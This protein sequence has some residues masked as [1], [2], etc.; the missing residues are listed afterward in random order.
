MLDGLAE[1]D[2][3]ERFG[4]ERQRLSVAL[5]QCGLRAAIQ[6]TNFCLTHREC[7]HREITTD[8]VSAGSRKLPHETTAPAGNF[9][10]PQ[11]LHRTDFF[12]NQLIPWAVRV[13]MVRLG[14]KDA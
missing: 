14:I 11:T 10:H 4:S 12:A 1:N 6:C 5:N 8:D 13:F 3:S 7:C 9:E 2:H